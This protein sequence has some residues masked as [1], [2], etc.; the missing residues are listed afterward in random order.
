MIAFLF[1]TFGRHRWLILVALAWW[2]VLIGWQWLAGRIA[3]RYR[4]EANVIDGGGIVITGV[5]R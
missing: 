5:P 4:V 1:G 2:G 3:R